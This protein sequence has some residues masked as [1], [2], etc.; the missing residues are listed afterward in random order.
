MEKK[1]SVANTLFLTPEQ[2]AQR[3]GIGVNRI[4]QLMESGELGHITIPSLGSRVKPL[5]RI[6]WSRC[7]P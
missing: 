7:V 4:R 6:Q 2:A 3:S 5:I 1:Q